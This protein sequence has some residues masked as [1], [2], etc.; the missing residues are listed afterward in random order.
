MRTFNILS[1]LPLAAVTLLA[2]FVRASNVVTLTTENFDSI[3]GQGKPALVEFYAS[4]CGHCKRL[5]PVWEELADAFSGA[6]QKDRVIIAKI[7]ADIEKEMGQRYGIQGFPTLKW[8]TANDLKNPTDYNGG[9]ELADLAAFVT[10]N[11]GIR[12]NI[13]SAAPSAVK[14][15]NAGTFERETVHSGKD[16]LIAFKAPWCGHCK[17]MTKPYE[18]VAQAF[19]SEP[20]CVVAEIPDSDSEFNRDL[21][22]AQGVSS[23]PTIKFY[24]RDGSSP[25]PYSGARTEEAFV[26]FLNEHCGTHRTPSGGLLETAGRALPLDKLASEFFST[27]SKA[28]REAIMQRARDVASNLT[29]KAGSAPAYYLKAMERVLEKGEDWLKKETAR[30]TKLADS[31]SLAPAKKDEITI[32]RNIL[33]SFVK[34]TF[35]EAAEAVKAAESVVGEATKSVHSVYDQATQAVKQEL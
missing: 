34:R 4:W 11:S 12:S 22:A 19:K 9:R 29:V 17:S 24:P 2:T 6:Y 33:A 1:L 8:F 32:K 27:P 25:I 13:K 14:Q 15:L 20:D 30:F 16:V 10:E 35:D 23:Y 26:N 5:A 21:A 7:D 28:D 18:A 31:S 3:I